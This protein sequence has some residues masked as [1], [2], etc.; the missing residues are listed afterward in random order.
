MARAAEGVGFDSIWVGDHLLYR[1]NGRPERGP[2]EV[3]PPW[4]VWPRR[5]NGQNRA[6]VACRLPRSGDAR[7]AGGDRARDQRGRLVP[8]LGAGWNEPEFRAFV[9]FDHRASRFEESRGDPAVDLGDRVTFE[10]RYVQ[11]D[12]AVLLPCPATLLLMVGSTGSR[13]L[14]AALPHVDAWNTWFDLVRQHA[15]RIRGA[16]CRGR[17]PGSASRS[18]PRLTR[19]ER[20]PPGGAR[21]VVR[22]RPHDPSAPPVTGPRARSRTPSAR[23][24]RRGRTVVLVIDPITEGSIRSFA[25]VLGSFD[26]S[27][28]DSRPTARPIS[29]RSP[30]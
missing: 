8:A 17:R 4:P 5:P 27:A 6:A 23:W 7:Q 19:A 3:R 12:D 26:R 10:G 16:E 22:E 11:V 15:W 24:R 13:V 14:A 25:G 18:R 21:P 9:P 2:W 30:G 29:R 28:G 1:G 20:L